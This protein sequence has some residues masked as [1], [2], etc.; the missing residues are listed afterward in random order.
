M[1]GL[2]Q[3]CPL[4]KA[5]NFFRAKKLAFMTKAGNCFV[6]HEEPVWVDLEPIT[7][8]RGIGLKSIDA[9]LVDAALAWMMPRN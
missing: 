4:L 1:M 6:D 5:G 7:R 8:S 3:A 9:T 2:H